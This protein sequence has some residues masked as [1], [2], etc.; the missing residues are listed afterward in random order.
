MPQSTIDEAIYQIHQGKKFHVGTF[1][2]LASADDILRLA[3]TVPTGRKAQL[4]ISAW[5]DKAA[6]YAFHKASAIVGSGAP[7]STVTD[8]NKVSDNTPV[9]TVLVTTGET[10]AET[11]EARAFGPGQM[12]PDKDGRADRE[13]VLGPGH[14]VV[15][16]TAISAATLANIEL[17]WTEEP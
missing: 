7:V 12:E 10:V 6:G 16:I 4:L 13:W 5:V 15:S 3:I 8:R 11:V 17:D 2:T 9:S 14:W 1:A